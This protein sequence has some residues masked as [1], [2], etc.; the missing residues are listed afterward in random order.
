MTP[1]GLGSPGDGLPGDA[2][3]FGPY[4]PRPPRHLSRLW[5]RPGGLGVRGPRAP[6]VEGASREIHLRFRESH[7]RRDRINP[8]QNPLGNCRRFLSPSVPA[9]RCRVAEMVAFSSQELC[10]DAEM[11]P[12]VAAFLN[13]EIR[14]ALKGFLNPKT[15]W[16]RSSHR[17]ARPLRPRRPCV[18]RSRGAA[19]Q[20]ISGPP[21]P[22]F[23]ENRVSALLFSAPF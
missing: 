2:L 9:A 5:P 16:L 4:S 19:S 8:P 1:C 6:R 7:V 20:A 17:R 13:T 11:E 22:R 21:A 12:N 23:L 14:W 3:G 10:L 15:F 18:L